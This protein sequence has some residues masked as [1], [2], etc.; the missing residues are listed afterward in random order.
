MLINQICT[1]DILVQVPRKWG[2]SYYL[3][4]TI[5]REVADQYA[6]TDDASWEVSHLQITF[7]VGQIALQEMWNKNSL[8][9]AIPSWEFTKLFDEAIRQII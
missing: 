1:N 7:S 9:E 8:T 6:G 3:C 4:T 5:Y 2:T